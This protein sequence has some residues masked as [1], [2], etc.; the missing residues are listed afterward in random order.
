M[1]KS[2][3][4]AFAIVATAQMTATASPAPESSQTDL[5]PVVSAPGKEFAR[6]KLIFLFHRKSEWS[7]EHFHLHYV[8]THARLGLRWTRN[9]L[10]YTVNLVESENWTDA[11]TEQW[12]P[13]AMDMLDP[14]NSYASPADFAHV[15]S[16]PISNGQTRYYVVQET[17]LKGAELSSPLFQPTPGVKVIWTFANGQK[18]PPPPSGATRVVDDRVISRLANDLDAS[19]KPVWQEV[20]SDVVVFRMAWA[21]KLEDLGSPETLAGAMIVREHRFRAYVP[22]RKSAD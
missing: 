3:L 14:R 5:P 11:L 4:A 19:G 13:S 21:E 22:G 9:L 12:V 8:E 2:A 10:G 17:V 6:E 16:D 20:P 7:R 1:N 18:L 15:R